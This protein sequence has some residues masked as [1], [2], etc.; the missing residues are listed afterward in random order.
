MDLTPEDPVKALK[1]LRDMI[2]DHILPRL[3]QL[4]EEVRLL[5]LVTWPVCQSIRETSQISDIENKRTVLR[6]LHQ[7]DIIELL[8]TKCDVSKKEL[9]FSTTHLTGEEM[10]SILS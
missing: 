9:Q 2:K 8:K 3:T 7:D 5:R 6:M 4:E 1:D 10:F